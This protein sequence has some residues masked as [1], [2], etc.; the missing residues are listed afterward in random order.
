MRR[1][2]WPLVLA[3][4]ACVGPGPPEAQSIEPERRLMAYGLNSWCVTDGPRAIV[5]GRWARHDLHTDPA[6]WARSCAEVD[7]PVEELHIYGDSMS[8]V[9]SLLVRTES[10]RVLEGEVPLIGGA[11]A[12]RPVP[13]P[14]P[15][16]A[17]GA[18]ASRCAV[19]TDGVM[20]WS[21]ERERPT[22]VAGIGADVRA[23]VVK[24]LAACV[25]EGDG[26][27][28][29]WGDVGDAWHDRPRSVFRDARLLTLGHR[30]VCAVIGERRR[31]FCFGRLFSNRLDA[32]PP[33]KVRHGIYD[34]F[35]DPVE[36]LINVRGDSSCLVTDGDLFCAASLLPDAHPLRTVPPRTPWLPMAELGQVFEHIGPLRS[37]ARI[38][39]FGYEFC[40]FSPGGAKCSTAA[41]RVLQAQPT[42]A[43]R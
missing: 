41:A 15:A 6:G 21:A 5:C 3:A 42:C 9:G 33:L 11:I 34:Q 31:L 38:V 12:L 22:R 7:D 17:I 10:G 28:S 14:G 20:C 24:G 43:A 26:R 8:D 36:Q 30:T 37:R 27:V 18:G 25:L 32:V 40:V 4:V 39:S 29:C 2:S 13:L 16:R 19:V 1:S 35:V 23:L